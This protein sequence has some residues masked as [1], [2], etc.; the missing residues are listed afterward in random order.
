MFRVN[1]SGRF[2]GWEQCVRFW[3]FRFMVSGLPT[4]IHQAVFLRIPVHLMIHDSG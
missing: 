3:V 1:P 2:G 4:A